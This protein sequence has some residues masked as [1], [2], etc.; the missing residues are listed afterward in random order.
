MDR[1]EQKRL[2]YEIDRGVRN[3]GICKV[4]PE[5]LER[6]NRSPIFKGAVVGFG[7]AVNVALAYAGATAYSTHRHRVSL[8]VTTWLWCSSLQ[9]ER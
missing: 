3:V 6:E 2:E 4:D 7:V 9:A 1:R 8:P 5:G